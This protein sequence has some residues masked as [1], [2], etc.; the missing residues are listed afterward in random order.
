MAPAQQGNVRPNHHQSVRVAQV[1]A[2]NQSGGR[3]ALDRRHLSDRSHRA[4]SGLADQ[5]GLTAGRIPPEVMFPAGD[6]RFTTSYHALPLQ[7][8]AT[9]IRVVQTGDAS[10]A[11]VV[12]CV[13]GWACSVYSFRRL[14][15]L[16]ADIGMRVIAIDLPGHGLSD[17]P[18]DPRLYT[19]DAQVECVLAAM[20]SLGIS[21]AL[22][23]GHS[24][25]GPICARAAVLAPDRITA[26]ALLAPAGFGTE[27]ELRILRA[28]TPRLIAPILP[29]LLHRWMISAVFRVVYGD[30]YRPT[31]RD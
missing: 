26:L 14:M 9:T 1:P 25:G 4:T 24:M 5:G 21:R 16:L 27:W 30:L 20:D 23:V 22:L 3:R 31:A 17:K 10:A 2:R 18:G 7:S 28:I 15:P 29:R 12:V 8:G 13:H 6:S 19:I 11:R